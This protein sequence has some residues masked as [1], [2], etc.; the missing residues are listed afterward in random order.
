M[1]HLYFVT[2]GPKYVRDLMVSNLQSQ[3]FTWKRKNLKTKKEETIR[4]QGNL[5]PIEFWEYVLPEE[6]LGEICHYLGIPA[7]G[8]QTH[9]EKMEKLA[10]AFRK[11]L[12]L[13]KIPKYDEKKLV[14][15][16]RLIYRAGTRIY[17]L[18]IKKD[19]RKDFDWGYNQEGL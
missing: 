3:T 9:S 15:E 5:K 17:G 7:D 13:T 2:C 10:W 14:I 18:G 16:P 12:G 6:S 1:V 8:K 11:G 4:V 19:D